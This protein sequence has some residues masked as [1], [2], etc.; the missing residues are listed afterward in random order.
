MFKTEQEPSNIISLY[1]YAADQS[2]LTFRNY[3]TLS[4]DKDFKTEFHIDTQFWASGIKVLT[5]DQ[6]LS[7]F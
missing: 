1:S 5:G 6:V 2:P 4:T 7:R 3:L